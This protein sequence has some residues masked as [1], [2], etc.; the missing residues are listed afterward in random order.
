MQREGGKKK[1]LLQGL[2]V[3]QNCGYAYS[4]AQCGVEGKKF[5]YYRCSSTIRITD[6]REKCTNKLVR[7]DMLETAIWEKVKNLLKNPEIIKNEYHRR[8]AENKNDES[9]DKKFARRE[10]QIKQGIEKLME[11]YYSQ[12]NV[13][14]KGYISEEEFKQT[15]KRMRERLR[16]IEEEK[17]K[18]VDQKAI[19]KGMNLIINSI[20]SLYSSV[21]SNLEQ[22]D[23]QTKRGIIKALVERIQIGYD[24]VEVAFRIEEPAQDGEIFN[25]QHCTGRH[26]KGTGG[27]CQVSFFVSMLSAT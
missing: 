24:Q 23:W 2:V 27:V 25:L 26:D 8:I 12:E 1:Y 5:S 19:E 17:K 10:N 11:D 18:V 3:C 22:L 14:D 16:G 15:M 20:K 7:T 6:G 4:G 9:S 13:G 21:K